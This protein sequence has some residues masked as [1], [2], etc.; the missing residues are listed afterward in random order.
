MQKKCLGSHGLTDYRISF[1]AVLAV[2]WM[3]LRLTVF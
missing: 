2:F 1:D 3:H